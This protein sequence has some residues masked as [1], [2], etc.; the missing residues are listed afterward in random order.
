[1][2]APL[3]IGLASLLTLAAGQPAPHVDMQRMSR[4]HAHARLR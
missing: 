1:M 4:H 2:K 3:F